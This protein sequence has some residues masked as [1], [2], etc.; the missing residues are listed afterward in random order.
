MTSLCYCFVQLIAFVCRGVIN[1]LFI[2]G[3]LNADAV[4]MSTMQKTKSDCNIVA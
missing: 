2:P 4:A 1:V 3:A